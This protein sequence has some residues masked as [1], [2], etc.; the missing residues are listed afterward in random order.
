MEGE[1]VAAVHPCVQSEAAADSAGISVADLVSV[2]VIHPD[3]RRHI[4]LAVGL[5]RSGCAEL[6]SRDHF[7]GMRFLKLNIRLAVEVFFSV[8]D[9]V[10]RRTPVGVEP[11]RAYSLCRA[12]VILV[13]Y[14]IVGILIIDGNAAPLCNGKLYIDINVVEI[15][16]RVGYG[17]S[18]NACILVL[19]GHFKIDRL[20]GVFCVSAFDRN[21]ADFVVILRL[22]VKAER[23]A[24]YA[25]CLACVVEA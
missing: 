21:A 10:D 25:S 3:L 13:V 17:V 4:P 22:N 8:S 7:I 1:I 24:S 5:C 19:G 23:R 16:H 14:V 20:S 15:V 11:E 2:V 6:G 9:P 12:D 18:G